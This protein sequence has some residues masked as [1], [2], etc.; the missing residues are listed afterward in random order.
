[1]SNISK[2][3]YTNDMT[4]ISLAALP[5]DSKAVADVLTACADRGINVDMISQTAPKGGRLSLSFSISDDSLA[6]ALTVL[7]TLRAQHPDIAPEILPGNC[8]L[9]FYDENMVATPGV[10]AKVFSLLSQAGVEVMLVT[11]S[12]YDISMLVPAHMLSDARNVLAEAFGLTPV[13]VAF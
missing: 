1:M 3:T 12:D 9:A 10:A 8:K 13:E 6:D 4:L 2:I 5:C 7:G 11:T